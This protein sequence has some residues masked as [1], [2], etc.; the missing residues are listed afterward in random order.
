MNR[1]AFLAM[2]G[3]ALVAS[4]IPLIGLPLKWVETYFHEISHGLAALATGG[5][6]ML[7]Q[8]NYNGS[9]LLGSIG[10]WPI[11]ISFA[12]YVGASLW[13]LAI[14][15]VASGATP[16]AGR[17]WSAALAGCVAVSVLL[18]AQGVETLV[19]GGLIIGIFVMATLVHRFGV[20]HIA[21]AFLGV[22]VALSALRAPLVL[23]VVG[24]KSDA[25]NLAELTLVPRIVWIALWAAFALFVLYRMWRRSGRLPAMTRKR[26]G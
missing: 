15:R 12:G 4:E 9:G 3:A 2:V 5:R 26:G 17:L 14:Y 24:G 11:V 7:I 13:G 1:A 6:I 25:A 19:I 22:S 18:W 23:L 21:L 20:A 16:N 10:G 8:L